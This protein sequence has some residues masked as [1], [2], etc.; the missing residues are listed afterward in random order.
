MLPTRET[1]PTLCNR[2]S[3]S[4]PAAANTSPSPLASTTV[5]AKM[6]CP[7][8]FAFKHSPIDR[9]LVYD[10][11]DAP[12]VQEY[13]DL[14]LFDHLDHQVF[15]SLRI[16]RR[17]YTRS[18]D[19]RLHRPSCPCGASF[20]RHSLANL[21]VSFDDVPEDQQHQS[22][23]STNR[24]NGHNARPRLHR[25]LRVSPRLQRKRRPGHHRQPVRRSRATQAVP[26]E[27]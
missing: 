10:R 5:L 14:G 4:A 8:R 17:V 9:A 23:P 22:R 7:T 20:L 21:L 26:D 1:S 19:R 12:A 25:P 15:H 27:V 16:N 6:A 11:I 13:L 3:Y 18:G 24:R 2:R